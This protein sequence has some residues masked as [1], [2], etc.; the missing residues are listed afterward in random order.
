MGH[1]EVHGEIPGRV[2]IACKRPGLKKAGSSFA[3]K[4]HEKRREGALLGGKERRQEQF[5]ARRAP[6]P[7]MNL[8]FVDMGQGDC[9]IVRCPDGK[10]IVIDCGSSG[11]LEDE[12]FREA[13]ETLVTWLGDDSLHAL[14]LTHPDRDHYNQ[15]V[16][17]LWLD[18]SKK[19]IQI[20]DVYFSVRA[21]DTS[22]LGNYSQNGVNNLLASDKVGSPTLHEVSIHP[23]E[24][25]LREWAPGKYAAPP[26]K[27]PQPTLQK[28]IHSGGEGPKQW[29]VTVIAGGLIVKGDDF[30]AASL[31]TLIKMGG[32]K[33]LLTGDATP[34]TQDF[35]YGKHGAAIKDVEVFQI[36]HHGS[37]ECAST[38]TFRDHVNPKS[39]VVSV[40]LL[41]DGYCL[42]RHSIIDD[43][44]TCSNLSVLDAP[45]EIDYWKM[46]EDVGLN[47]YQQ[48]KKVIEDWLEKHGTAAMDAMD[49][50]ECK[51]LSNGSGTFYWLSHPTEGEQ[52][53]G[54]T[55][56]GQVVCRAPMPKDIWATG[57]MGTMTVTL[58]D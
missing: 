18:A 34:E 31:V 5:A 55:N 11:N 58:T 4:G 28:V 37:A 8:K 9:T 32:D 1:C 33:V 39:T 29:S 17:L 13:K 3:L 26:T 46:P 35:V 7:E 44:L 15:L 36:P 14:L 49:L 43:W 2:C 27:T 23:K 53:Y 56:K 57:I 50:G 45:V 20:E 41:R 38:K 16:N 19:F 40:G 6:K 12:A 51:V 25:A 21:S 47:E 52:Y 30:N 48:V 24:S 22:P 54:I 42:P 10:V